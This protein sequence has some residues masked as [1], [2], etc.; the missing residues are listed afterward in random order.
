MRHAF[1][2]MLGCLVHKSADDGLEIWLVGPVIGTVNVRY[3]GSIQYRLQDCRA[4]HTGHAGE[5]ED[6]YYSI[7]AV[8]AML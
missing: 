7:E 5:R 2:L 8:Q 4:H 6:I 1:L 3:L